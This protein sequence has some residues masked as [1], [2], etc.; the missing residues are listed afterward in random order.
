MPLP[1]GKKLYRVIVEVMYYAVADDEREAREHADD[2]IRDTGFLEDQAF[3]LEVTH[4]RDCTYEDD[5]DPT[6]LV[7]GGDGDLTLAAAFDAVME[8]AA[9][10]GTK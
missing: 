10:G 9:S 3:A 5:W 1:D 6:S 4:A 8:T 7:Y 2:A